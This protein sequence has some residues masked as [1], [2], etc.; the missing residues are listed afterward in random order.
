MGAATVPGRQ[1]HDDDTSVEPSRRRS[2]RR[3]PRLSPRCKR[4]RSRSK[5]RRKK[6]ETRK[7]KTSLS[8][9]CLF[10]ALL[11]S[12]QLFF[13]CPRLFFNQN[14]QK[15]EMGGAAVII[16]S[17]AEW[18]AALEKATAEGKAVSGGVV[19]V[20]DGK[21]RSIAFF[22]FF[23]L[24]FSTSPRTLECLSVLS[25]SFDGASLMI[26]GFRHQKGDT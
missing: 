4:A 12:L 16:N 5:K 26:S 19:G 6:T 9:F 2:L 22:F 3:S 13:R 23:P 18:T 25:A 24:A 17:E 14:N 7:K 10:F 20:N 11:F 21:R 1:R 8:L 15:P